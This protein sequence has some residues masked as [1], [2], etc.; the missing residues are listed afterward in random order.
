MTHHGIWRYIYLT[1]VPLV[2]FLLSKAMCLLGEFN[3]WSAGD[4]HWAIKNDFGVWQLF[5]PDGPD[6]QPAIPHRCTQP[7][8]LV[9][10]QH[11]MVFRMNG[12]QILY[13]LLNELQ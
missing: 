5:L 4:D 6:G 1:T 13:S 8:K 7:I 12:K 10:C 3:N 11:F 2:L 9:C